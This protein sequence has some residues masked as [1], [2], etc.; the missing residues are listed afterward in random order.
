MFIKI[1]ISSKFFSILFC[2]E[3]KLFKQLVFLIS[4]KFHLQ[5]ENN[6]GRFKQKHVCVSHK[7]WLHMLHELKVE[8]Y[9]MSSDNISVISVSKPQIRTF[10]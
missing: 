7:S 4:K 5:E 2:N 10:P 3:Q 6:N 9:T 8:V 1:K